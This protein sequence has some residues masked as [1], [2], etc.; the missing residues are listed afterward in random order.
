M[1]TRYLKLPFY[2]IARPL[3]VPYR[4]LHLQ[5]EPTD[6]CNQ[7]CIMCYRDRLIKKPRRMTLEQFQAII[8]DVRP[9]NVNISGLGE[10]L[11]HKNIFD[12][13]RY[14]KT[15][16]M[17]VTFPSNLTIANGRL[18]D[19]VASG[20][21]VLK[22]SLDAVDRETYQRIR[23]TDHFEKVV[24][25]VRGINELKK[26]RKTAVPHIRINYALQKS[27][28]EDLCRAVELTAELKAEA[29]YIQYLDYVEVDDLKEE[30]V[31]DLTPDHLKSTLMRARDIAARSG[32]NSNISIWLKDLE[33][34]MNK[35]NTMGKVAA[36]KRK[37]YFP[38]ISTFIEVNG[39]VKACPIFTR[40]RGEGRL[41]NIFEQSFD[42]IWNGEGYMEIRRSLKEGKRV[43]APCRQC[44][45]Q[46]LT[47]IFLIFTK[48]LPGWKP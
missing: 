5:V 3:K 38:W 41:G 40:K 15:K 13:V 42:S 37:C 39:D 20:I 35:M 6:A 34:Y 25:A 47:N 30:L 46:S 24:D 36:L 17:G 11:L 19:I 18:E 21:D 43:H 22:V 12:M 45:P 9:A 10:P 26:E 14:A 28:V 48:M 7:K 8:D 33:L 16:G 27:N 29:L 44:V 32:I 4:P 23:G 2:I 31:G 1:D